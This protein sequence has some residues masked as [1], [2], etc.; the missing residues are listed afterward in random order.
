MSNVHALIKMDDYHN[1]FKQL[2]KV[3]H[4]LSWLNGKSRCDGKIWKQQSWSGQSCL[5]ADLPFVSLPQ[6]IPLNTAFTCPLSRAKDQ[7]PP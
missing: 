2:N 6:H 7:S 3:S 1:A 5:L 4:W